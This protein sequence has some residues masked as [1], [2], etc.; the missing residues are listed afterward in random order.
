MKGG[1]FRREKHFRLVTVFSELAGV[2]FSNRCKAPD[3]LGGYG[4]CDDS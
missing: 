3:V 4:S 1:G 2:P